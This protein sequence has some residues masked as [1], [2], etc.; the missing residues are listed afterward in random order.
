MIKS[1]NITIPKTARYFSLGDIEAST[2]TFWIVLHGYGQKAEDFAQCFK[3][4][5]TDKN[6]IIAPEGLSRFYKNG[7]YGEVVSSWMT[8]ED[9][10][11]E[12][13]DYILYLDTLIEDLL[14]KS[15][16]ARV[17]ILG[18]SQGVA[19]ACRWATNGRFLFEK[20]ILWAGETPPELDW[21]IL[22]K[23]CSKAK[24]HF[25]YGLKDPYIQKVHI[26][27]LKKTLSKHNVI[28]EFHTFNGAHQLNSKILSDLSQT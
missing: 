6:T 25:V 15:P 1:N 9:R 7:F 2:K 13:N 22:K 4:L 19:T 5:K 21:G 27:S 16:K 17:N 23:R 11:N 20:L 10:L 12:I 18:F 26:E 14:K 8:K 28:S 24:L 3:I